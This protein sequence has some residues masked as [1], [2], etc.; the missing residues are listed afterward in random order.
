MMRRVFIVLLLCALTISALGQTRVT[1]N[2]G[3]SNI[4]K[5]YLYEVV[6]E[7][8]GMHRAIDSAAVNDKQFVFVLE[9]AQP[10]LYFIGDT[11][12]HGGYFF[13][14][15]NDITLEYVSSTDEQIVWSVK[16]SPL[17]QIYREFIDHVYA[18]TFGA[19][20][21]SLNA[22]FYKAREAGDR[23]EMAR[24]KE[25]SGPYYEE[26]DK[27][28][29]ELVKKYI[30]NN[31]ENPF[32]MYLYYN[33]VFLRKDFPTI[34]SIASEKAYISDF[35]KRAK[36][37]SYLPKI[38]K[39]LALYE[40]CAIGHE[41]PEIV[42]RDTLGNI[43]RLSDFRGNYVLVDFWNSYCHWCREETP[44]LKKALEQFGGKNFKI[45]GVSSDMYKDKWIEAIHEDGSYWDHL[46]LEKGND[47]MD[48]Y[49]IKGIPHIILVAPDGTIL[50][51]ELRGEDLVKVP[52][53]LMD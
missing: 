42:G 13:V 53:K 22:L 28:E 32:G 49:C 30:Q 31:R 34:E 50:A 39:R 47:V 21:D 26:G 36:E 20:R 46:M 7:Y 9:H 1:G 40:N 11:P 44:A 17:D 5:V 38:E 48:R 3:M 6:N 2:V 16:D 43:V 27:R 12:W 41:A 8:R 45:L 52:E 10:E 15:G 19:V 35:G 37:T 18:E 29:R 24:I 33:R 23:E 4:D 14:D 25:E 51:K